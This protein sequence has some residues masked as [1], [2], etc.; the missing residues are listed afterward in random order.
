MRVY[1]GELTVTLEWACAR[2]T[3]VEDAAECIDVGAAVDL[4][5]LDLLRRNVV[6]RA[7]EAAVSGQAADGRHVAGET[8]VAHVG[9]LVLSDEDVAR[10]HVPVDEARCMGRIERVAYLPD[11]PE[12]PSRLERAVAAEEFAEIRSRD[13]LHREVKHTVLVPRA[14]DGHYVRVL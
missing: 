4:S 1:D 11:E 9:V 14:E 2:Q 7:D 13:V 6:D 5:A 12:R 3:L 10:L 8:E